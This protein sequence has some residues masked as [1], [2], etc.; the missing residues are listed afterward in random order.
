VSSSRSPIG[1][2]WGGVPSAAAAPGCK[3]AGRRPTP[4]SGLCASVTL[5]LVPLG[6]L[7]SLCVLAPRPSAQVTARFDSSR[8]WEH[9]RQ[10]VAIGPRPAGSPAIEQARAYIKAQLAAAGVGLTEQAWDDQTPLGRVHMVNLV[11]TIPGA[12]ADRIVISGH[13]DT[14]LFRDIRFVGA[15]D[16]GSS[17]A[18]LIEMA[19][20]LKARRNPLTIELLFLDGEEAVCLNWD[21]C[22]RPGAPDNTYGSRHYVAAGKQNGTLA[23]I[24]AHILVDMIGDRDLRLKREL[25]ST[26][27]LT[28]LIWSAAKLQKLDAYFVPQTTQVEDDHLPFLQAGVPSVDIIDLEYEPWH[29]AKDNLDAVS[30]RSLQVVGDVVLAALPQLEARIG[31]TA[32]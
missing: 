10:L 31:R 21:D 12:R 11:A 14:K 3:N 27:W 25:N 16:G 2:A 26:P 32:P 5:W 28:D 15:S 17:A 20:V 29:T 1:P 8:A 13:Y 6:V 4:G 9:L 7:A 30:A 22:S 18:F 19:R 23:G 24:K